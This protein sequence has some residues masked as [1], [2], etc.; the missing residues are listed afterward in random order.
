MNIRRTARAE[1]DLIDIWL[2]IAAESLTAA[3][4]LLDRI[5]RRSQLLATQ[6][7]S[8]VARHDLGDGLREVVIGSYLMFYRVEGDEIVILRVLHGKR[9]LTAENIEE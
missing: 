1:G 8:G 3:D 5:E 4:R 7:F 9:D 2:Y 6:P